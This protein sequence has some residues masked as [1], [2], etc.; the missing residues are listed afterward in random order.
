MITDEQVSAAHEAWEKTVRQ[1]KLRRIKARGSWP[2]DTW[3]LE[4]RGECRFD[5]STVF[6]DE[7]AAHRFE[8]EGA[9]KSAKMLL[10]D[11][12]IRAMLAAAM[13]TR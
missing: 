11:K 7:I 6:D 5:P 3:L 9:E 12:C 4:N 10:R 8:G 1:W 13:S 2:H